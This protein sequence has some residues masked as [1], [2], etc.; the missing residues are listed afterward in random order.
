MS[1]KL[2]LVGCSRLGLANPR[3]RCVR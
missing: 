1:H 3:C 2:E